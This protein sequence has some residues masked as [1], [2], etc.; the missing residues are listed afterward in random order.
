MSE[1][2]V[3]D[4][5]N[6]A[7]PVA[8]I[9]VFDSGVGGLSILRALRVR[10]P[11]A[12]MV[13]VGDVAHAP[14]G[15]RLQHEVVVRSV[16]MVEW[17]AGEGAQMIVVACNTATVLGIE[18]LRVRW[19]KRVFV[20]VEPGVKPAVTRSRRRRI[21]VMA[22]QATAGSERLRHLIARYADNA[23]VHVQACPGLASA[24]ERGVL[25]GPEL[26]D[27]LRPSC[28][29][30]RAAD[31]DTVVLGCTHY[32][33]VEASIRALLGA[34]IA[35]IDTATAVAERAASLWEREPPWFDPAPTLRVISTGAIG[36]MQRL[37]AQCP[38]FAGIGVE[39]LAL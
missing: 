5:F 28:D 26:L 11:G 3:F 9:G 24:I 33:F 6:D 22:T 29:A 17:L 18:A 31:V 2:P 13:Y 14:Y 39:A 19:P 27:V 30:I 1:S 35:L 8:R 38:E 36:T 7:P 32:A 21:A 10:L 20:G 15:G 37:S 25:H 4:D 12:S 34:D 16:R 23:V